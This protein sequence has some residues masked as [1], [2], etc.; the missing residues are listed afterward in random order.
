MK[1]EVQGEEK[2]E[3]NK[4]EEEDEE[5]KWLPFKFSEPGSGQVMG[6]VNGGRNIM[7]KKN[8]K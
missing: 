1:I 5:K 2:S 6:K 8:K 7:E 4:V 3:N